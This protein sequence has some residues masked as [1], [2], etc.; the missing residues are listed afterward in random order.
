MKKQKIWRVTNNVRKVWIRMVICQ[1]ILPITTV[2]R[3]NCNYDDDLRH[4]SKN[5]KKHSPSSSP[6]KV[7]SSQIVPSQ[8]DLLT[9][10]RNCIENRKILNIVNEVLGLTYIKVARKN[11]GLRF[12]ISWTLALFGLQGIRMKPTLVGYLCSR[13][14]VAVH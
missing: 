14:T 6:F 10:C 12:F 3:L 7:W 1:N 9:K 8:N 11:R 2:A 4:K 13:P 5:I